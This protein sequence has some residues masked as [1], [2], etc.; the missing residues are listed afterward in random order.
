MRRVAPGAHAGSAGPIHGADSGGAH[1]V[2]EDAL[3]LRVLDFERVRVRAEL[4]RHGRDISQTARALGLE[5]SHLYNKCQQLGID[6][7][8]LES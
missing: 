5:R 2:D 3:A 8:N 7:K 6:L 4:K 1:K